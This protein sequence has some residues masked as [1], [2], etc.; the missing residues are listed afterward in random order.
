M[1]SFI[2]QALF[3]L[4]GIGCLLPWNAF[5]SETSYYEHRF[6]GMSYEN[7]FESAFGI[8]YNYSNL[9]ALFILLGV[10]QFFS[11]RSLV[12]GSCLVCGAIF[13][14]TTVLT[15]STGVSSDLLFAITMASVLM[16]GILAA[17]MIAGV[18]GMAAR[19]SRA[20]GSSY[21]SGQAFGG[22]AASVTSV[23][24]T[25]SGPMK[26]SFCPTVNSTAFETLKD[27]VGATKNWSAFVYF[28]IVCVVI[29]S[30]ILAF[31]V[32]RCREDREKLAMELGESNHRLAS[33]TEGADEMEDMERLEPLVQNPTSLSD[34]RTTEDS[35]YALNADEYH[36][37][38]LNLLPATESWTL[39]T[40]RQ[41]I[42]ITL[43]PCT[44]VLMTFLVTLA[45]FPE[46]TSLTESTEK[47]KPGTSRVFN[48]LFVP[49]LFVVFNLAD[50]LGRVVQG[51]WQPFSGR[52]LMLLSYSRLLLWP[53]FWF[54]RVKDSRLVIIFGWDWFPFLISLVCGFSNGFLGT[55]SMLHASR[56][57]PVAHR[58][59]ASTI[60]VLALTL[61][62][63]LGSL[64][65]YFSLWIVNG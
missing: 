37:R 2:D 10:Q 8:A 41:V 60:S 22:I 1:S 61:G 27:S 55:A 23:V 57:V 19:F 52:A 29:F 38:R 16:C 33:M 63:S 44:A 49:I 12:V 48:D 56:L 51:V 9:A 3:F 64:L 36:L 21:F 45:V 39:S 65:S 15:V 17:P 42:V 24:T 7:S 26:Q 32:L 4:L 46:V 25:W 11:E 47:C 13:V 62:L 14:V 50:F 31:S 58:E 28:F 34:T 30:C 20:C 35:D 54:A 18:T 43:Y 59:L 5:I 6:K 53:F 40:I